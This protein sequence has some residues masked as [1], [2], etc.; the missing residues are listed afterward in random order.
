DLEG[1]LW[2][3]S[4]DFQ[5]LISG[6]EISPEDLLRRYNLSLLQTSLFKALHLKIETRA[7]GWE[8]KVLLRALKRL[9]LMYTAERFEGG[10][11]IEVSGPA[12]ILKMT[13]RYGT[14]LAKL[15]P[16]V[17]SMSHWRILAE[18]SR[19]KRMLSLRLDSR[20]R[21]LFPKGGVKEP[22]YDS[23]LERRF[24]SIAEA[25]GW[26]AIREPEPLVAGHSILLPDFLLVKGPARVYVEVMGFWTPEYIEKKIKKL[27]LLKE[28]I[29]IV[30]RKDLLC[31]RTEGLPK[32]V[33]YIEGRIDKVALLRKLNELERRAIEEISLS[34]RDL[35]GDIVDLRSLAKERGMRIDQLKSALSLE[36][37]EVLG[38][39]AVRKEVLESLKNR[40][41]PRKVRELK[42]MLREEGLPEDVA[43][44]LAS[45]LGY[46][47]IWHGLDED[48]AELY[49]AD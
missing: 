22:Q 26:R 31:S 38:D 46:E 23:S 15:I 14:S 30:A 12:S 4:D 18:I 33:F 25:G 16:Y 7:Q 34:D 28:P 19:N 43:L 41:L 35:E 1:S 49:S 6:P 48:E 20:A 8:V 11:A 3:D 32:D 5:V 36:S 17:V 37:Y 2:A 9:G 29:L 21:G 39:Y 47:V 45:A 24:A 40:K 13:T 44:P 27:S 10:V 42:I